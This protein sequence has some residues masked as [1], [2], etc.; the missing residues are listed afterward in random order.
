MPSRRAACN[1]KFGDRCNLK[2]VKERTPAH[3]AHSAV[4]T[5]PKGDPASALLTAQ[6]QTELSEPKDV[7]QALIGVMRACWLQVLGQRRG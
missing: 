3:Q 6:V 4:V 2:H 7:V 5:A 1:C